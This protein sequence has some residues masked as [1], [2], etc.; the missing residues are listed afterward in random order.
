MAH[1]YLK[2]LIYLFVSASTLVAE[3]QQEKPNIIYIYAD[4]L[5]YGEI[6]AYGQK[7]IETPHLDRMADEGMKFTQ[8]YTSSPVCAPARGMLLTGKHGGHAY[9]RGNYEMGGFTDYTEGGQMP[10]PEGTF[11][12]PLMLKNAGYATGIIGKWGL[13]M[14]N[15]TGDPNKQGFDY[16]YGYLDQKQAHNYYPTHLWENGK[17]DT[18]RN[19]EVN[20]HVRINPQTATEADFQKYEGLD[21]APE[22]MTEKA[23]AFIDQHQHK[24][25]FLYLPYTIPH[26]GLQAPQEWVE[27]YIGKFK[28]E[29]PYYGEQGYNPSRYPLST[30][31]A[32]ISYLDA[33]VGLVMDKIKN[34]GLDGNTIIMFSSD[35][36]AT[37]NGG[38]QAKYFNSL[39]NLRGYKMDLFEGGIR[40]P[41]IVRWPG[42]IKAGTQSDLISVQ[43]DMMATFAELAQTETNYTDGISLLPTL[44][45]QT[46]KQQQREYIYFEYPE[47][48]GQVAVR[49]GQ[50]KAVRIDVKKDKN[51]PWMLFN[52]MEDPSEQRNVALQHPDII[53]RMDE[54]QQREHQNSHILEWEF[55]NNKMK[56]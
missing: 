42:K 4:D 2:A 52:L 20:M 56:K 7:L 50:W 10:L 13:G 9:I 41:F 22:K 18:L 53:K 46:E 54:I 47:K 12:I 3:G 16:A 32:M 21:Y 8:H 23:L 25:F 44:T 30:Y 49:M 31:A 5:G 15:T 17:W 27:K 24:P 40:E 38:V 48:G 19:K 37:F 29:K 6:G 36:G 55:L 26:V 51:S 1:S 28:E 45:G 33:Q 39:R 11:T 43:Y 34:L 14:I 35:N